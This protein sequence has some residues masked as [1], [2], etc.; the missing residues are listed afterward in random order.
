M[1]SENKTINIDID[2]DAYLYDEDTAITP[3][4]DGVDEVP[5]SWAPVITLDFHQMNTGNATLISPSD[6]TSLTVTGT[7]WET[8]PLTEVG[9]AV[10]EDYGTLEGYSGQWANANPSNENGIGSTDSNEIILAYLGAKMGSTYKIIPQN[11]SISFQ[12]GSGGP[13]PTGLTWRVNASDGTA[14]QANNTFIN[15]YVASLS[16]IHI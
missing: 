13:L 6:L 14:L 16:L 2:G 9:Y 15:I 10:V 7:G 3:N 5:A 12:S 1:P 8:T 11:E 4:E